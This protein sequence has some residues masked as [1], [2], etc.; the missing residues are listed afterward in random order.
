MTKSVRPFRTCAVEVLSVDADKV[1]PRPSSGRPRRRQ[2][3]PVEWSWPREEFGSRSTRRT[4]SVETVGQ[5]YDL[6][7][8]KLDERSGRRR[9]AI[10]GTGCCPVWDAGGLLGGPPRSG[11][12]GGTS[13]AGDWIRA[14]GR[15]PK[16]DRRADA[17]SSS[18]SRPPPRRWSSRGRWRP[19]QSHRRHRRNGGRGSPRS[20]TGDRSPRQGRARVSPS[21]SHD[22]G[23]CLWCVD[24]AAIRF[25]GPCETICTACS[26]PP[27]PSATAP[28]RSLGIV[29][30]R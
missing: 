2:P 11:H 5:A 8:N 24:L 23:Q 10:P 30:T 27:T 18:R 16:D 28:A 6:V 14:P 12:D 3:G 26:A 15:T 13:P 19:T 25:Q 29:A 22:D 21:S 1:V 17:C 7:V 20:R 4:S 9:V